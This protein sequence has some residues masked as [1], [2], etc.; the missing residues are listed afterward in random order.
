MKNRIINVLLLLT[1]VSMVFAA[2]PVKSVSGEYT[3]YDDGSHSRNECRRIA[4]EQARIAALAKEFGT[5]VSQDI[6]QSDRIKGDKETN[7][8]LSLSSTEVKGEWLGDE[9]EPEYEISLD[10]DE[11]LVVKCKVKGKAR[12][13]TNESVPFDALVLRNGNNKRNSDN[14][15]RDGD[16]MYLYFSASSDG[17][18]AV[19]LQGEDG[20]VYGLLPY[21][22]ASGMAKV[23]KN[24]EYIFFDPTKAGDEFGPV[25]SLYL[26]A[27]D[28]VEYNKVCVVFSPQPY[29]LPMMSH[30][31]GSPIPSV[32]YADFTK[33]LSKSR[34]NDP[35]MGVKSMNIEIA[36]KSVSL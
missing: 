20:M 26:T 31:D 1:F 12:A 24:Y 8:F 14:R 15:F 17:Y 2:P 28:E 34:R 33:W 35:K 27:P 16:D 11:N 3:Y 6:L 13:I 36:P 5:V 18:V 21:P 9:G 19:F 30:V 25:E 4:A 7:N 32:S 10:K 22:Q 29:Q 23:K